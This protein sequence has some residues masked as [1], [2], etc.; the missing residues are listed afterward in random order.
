VLFKNLPINITGITLALLKST[1]FV[2]KQ[3]KEKK[4][5]KKV[6]EEYDNEK[7]GN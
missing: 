3:R 7:W 2:Q 5:K 4:E 6:V 1:C